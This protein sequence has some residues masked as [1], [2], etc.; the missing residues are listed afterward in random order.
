[1]SHTVEQEVTNFGYELAFS[2]INEI[3]EKRDTELDNPETHLKFNH[4][5]FVLDGVVKFVDYVLNPKT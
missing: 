5:R 1:M 2:R 3:L 4:A